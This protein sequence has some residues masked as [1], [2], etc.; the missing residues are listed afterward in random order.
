MICCEVYSAVISSN[1]TVLFIK[2]STATIYSY[3]VQDHIYENITGTGVIQ[4]LAELKI[5]A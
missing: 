4:A 3:G 2:Q 1:K 5:F